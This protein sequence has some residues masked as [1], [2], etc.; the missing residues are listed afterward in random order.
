MAST[1]S[2]RLRLELP[3]TGEKAGTWG[4]TMNLFM[5]TLLEHA[6]AGYATISL[7]GTP[8]RTLTALNGSTDEAR[9]AMLNFT[10]SPGAAATVICPAVTKFYMVRNRTDQPL[11]FKTPSGNGP[12]LAANQLALCWV[13]GTNVGLATPPIDAVTGQITT[14]VAGA[15]SFGSLAVSGQS[16]FGTV[17]T[18]STPPLLVTAANNG[19]LGDMRGRL[20]DSVA[21]LRFLSNNGATEQFRFYSDVTNFAIQVGP[22]AVNALVINQSNRAATFAGSLGVQGGLSVGNGQ[23]IYSGGLTITNGAAWIGG[24]VT[25]HRPGAPSTGSLYFG[26]SGNVYH[27]YDGA[28]HRINGGSQLFFNGQQVWHTGTFNPGHY[29]NLSNDVIFAGYVEAQFI[30]SERGHDPIVEVH[31]PGTGAGGLML[32]GDGKLSIV[33]TDGA[34]AFQ[35]TLA[36]FAFNGDFTAAGNVT[37][38]SERKLKSDIQPIVDALGKVLALSGYTY[39]RPDLDGGARRHMGLIV[40]EVRPVAPELVVGEEGQ[41]SIAY[42]NGLALL[43]EAV[44]ALHARIEDMD[45]RL[46]TVELFS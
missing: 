21:I 11:T 12:T 2:T 46:D 31:K 36:G 43:I 23:T 9:Y 5:G 19:V 6:I 35:Q 15:G 7:T 13:D 45:E 41:G 29:A 40:D 39:V 8:T 16:A 24:D 28:D 32:T 26:T 10:G 30:R 17:P 27:Y 44:K 20:S 42:G 3:N 4:Q 37:A 22:S 18:A 34:G 25:T 1:Y 38:S 33:R 14:L